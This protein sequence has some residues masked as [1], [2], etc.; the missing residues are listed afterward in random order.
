MWNKLREEK[1]T[2]LTTT[3]NFMQL[4]AQ[5]MQFSSYSLP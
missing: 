2:L 1:K 3:E 4:L 5:E